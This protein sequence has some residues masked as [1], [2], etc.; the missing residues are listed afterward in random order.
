MKINNSLIEE[1]LAIKIDEIIDCDNLALSYQDIPNMLSFMDSEKFVQQM[2][3]NKNVK[4][5]FITEKLAHFF[6]NTEIKKII[7]DDPRYYFYTL[8]NYLGK[9]N[10]KKTDSII[11]PTAIIH[12]RAYVCEYNV[13]IGKNV[14]IEPNVS[15][16]ADVII[17]D[18]CIIRANTVVGAEG[19]EHKRTSK[20]ILS[21]FHTGKVIIGNKVEIGANNAISKGFLFGDTLI[22][23]ETRTDNLVHIAHSAQIGKRC[24]LPA[25]AMIAGDSR[26]GD[27]CWIGPNASIS[28]QVKIGDK[29]FI[30]IGA[31]VTRNVEEKQTV[32]GNFAIEHSKFIN[33]IKSIR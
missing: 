23:D 30:T 22:G 8:K 16:L 7:C 27:D 10:Y 18:D 25:C 33:F 28:S 31:V 21:I 17:G 11:D 32:T 20:G 6:E 15:I 12:P 2:L 13:K 9:L 26:I 3:D 14:I 1:V 29:A 5:L 19:F 24:F 4:A